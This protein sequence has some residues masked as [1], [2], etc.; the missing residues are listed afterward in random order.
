MTL[1]GQIFVEVQVYGWKKKITKIVI[2][3]MHSRNKLQ[4]LEIDEVLK[5]ATGIISVVVL[6]GIGI[7]I[8]YTH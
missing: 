7:V 6:L 3:A 4:S 1:T 2:I 5:K 8:R